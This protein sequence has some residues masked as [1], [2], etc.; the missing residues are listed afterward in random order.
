MEMRWTILLVVSVTL[1]ALLACVATL[2]SIDTSEVSA[3]TSQQK[4]NIVYILP[5]TWTPT[6]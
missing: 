1:A 6:P 2:V 5:T 3:Q 4:P